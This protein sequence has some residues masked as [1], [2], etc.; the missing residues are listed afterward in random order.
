[1]SKEQPRNPHK[2]AYG[3]TTAAHAARPHLHSS[4]KQPGARSLAPLWL[5]AVLALL[6]AFSL[7]AG[8]AQAAAARPGANAI[9][10]TSQTQTYTYA[11]QITFQ[12]QASDSAGTI[13][14]A[15]LELTVP[16]LDIDHRLTVPVS[17]PGASVS[18]TYR[19]DP[20]RDYF[21]PFTPI[22]Y[23]WTLSDNAR[24]TLTGTDQ[25]FDFVDTRFA[26]QH[27]SQNELSI[28]WYDQGTAYG[29]SILNTATQ[30]AT[31]IEKDLNGTLTAPIRVLVYASNED[32]RGG[33]PSNTPNWAGG[34]ALIQ[35]D[36]ALIVVGESQHPL[37][38]DLPHELTHLIF[39]EIAGLNCGGCPLWFDEGMAVY[40]Q[41]YHEPEMQFAF[42]DA[43]QRKALLP[44]S[45]LV[46]RFP[47]DADRAELAYAQSWNF[48]TYLYSTYGQP[49][50]AQL[51]DA[52][53]T[54]AFDAAFQRAFS[55]SVGQ[56]EN[57]WRGSLGLPPVTDNSAAT[58]SAGGTT[59]GAASN[60]SSGSATLTTI[61]LGL[62]LLLLVG[63]AGAFFMLRRGRPAPAPVNGA[64]WPMPAA[65]QP[66][67]YLPGPQPAH[68]PFPTPLGIPTD[69]RFR[70]QIEQ[71]QALL[72]SINELIATETR[73]EAQRAELERQIAFYAVQERQ[74][75]AEHREDQALLALDR[76]QALATHLPTLQQQLEQA[77]IQ[78]AQVLEQE[79]RISAELEAAFSQ[80]AMAL[81]AARVGSAWQQPGGNM[82]APRR[83]VSQE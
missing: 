47:E 62:I 32:L 65:M 30:E 33:L 71:R 43:V 75:R 16:Q 79:R 44:F 46:E 35:F 59:S 27:L 23:H 5:A 22:T 20:S 13:T 17:E 52:L 12:V 48:I 73:L 2:E 36:E 69:E 40:H 49:K 64:L 21:P 57:Q 26:W 34:A 37:Q 29:Q 38:R 41:L 67:A 54:T 58:P 10:I 55:R 74:A 14:S 45:S 76:R 7:S 39:H 11:T 63:M 1:M 24:H 50:V 83:R 61:G 31:S 53:P 25:H 56:M 60:E 77:R 72:R 19:Y 80:Q 51:V 42:D 3:R 15:Q 4:M 66:P 28:Y 82:P 78:R 68:P 6:A 18:L 70:R 8:H 81:S 9:T